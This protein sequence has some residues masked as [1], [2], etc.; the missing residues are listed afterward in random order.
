MATTELDT[1]LVKIAADTSQLRG[2]LAKATS[3]M[4]KS[5]QAMAKESEKTNAALEKVGARIKGAIMGALGG[6]SVAKLVSM[7]RESLKWAETLEQTAKWL[8][9]TAT[10]LQA[11]EDGARDAGIEQGRFTQAIEKMMGNLADAAADPKSGPSLIF[12][13]LGIALRDANGQLKTADAILPQLADKIKTLGQGD[14]LIVGKTLFGDRMDEVVKVLAGGSDALARMRSE[15][16]RL[17]PDFAEQVRKGAD[18]NR[19]FEK[20]ERQI[21]TSLRQ[22]LIDLGPVLKSLID[23]VGRMARGL[24]NAI[25]IATDPKFASEFAAKMDRE[26]AAMLPGGLKRVVQPDLDRQR[27]AAARKQAIDQS[28]LDAAR[29]A[30]GEDL[31]GLPSKP[32]PDRIKTGGALEVDEFTK[33]IRE[34]Q[35][36]AAALRHELDFGKAAAANVKAIEAFADAGGKFKPTVEQVRQFSAALKKVEEGKTALAFK[37]LAT[38][39]ERL[40][41]IVAAEVSGNRELVAILEQRFALEEKLGRKLTEAELA[42]A[43]ALAKTRFEMEQTR[44][45]AQAA[46]QSLES[47]V[48]GFASTATSEMNAFFDGQKTGWEALRDFARKALNDIA[49]EIF[50]LG[51]LNPILNALLGGNRPGLGDFGGILG[52]LLGGSGGFSGVDIIGG[53]GGFSFFAEGGRPPVGVPSIVGERGPELFVPNVAGTIVPNHKLG[54]SVTYIDARGADQAAI[55]RLEQIVRAQGSDFR[56][57]QAGEPSRVVGH[58]I[59]A[60]RGGPRSVAAQL[61]A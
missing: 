9:T 35:R 25:R 45:R 17:N 34:A 42:R 39:N 31:P 49:N 38:E 19:E 54:G 46:W 32:P 12:Q 43:D 16:S 20:M 47:L 33:K 55:A 24:S 5:M 13:Q 8:G 61:G 52:G 21:S 48:E 37:D 22:A 58:V 11:Y 10:N 26:A 3:A 40:A 36:E 23:L 1:L 6:L 51:V 15:F 56:R 27:D 53:A 60:R 41:Q 14:T 18:L 29:R 28:A 2:E 59:D 44:E 30:M 50:K 7:T 57:W 4:A